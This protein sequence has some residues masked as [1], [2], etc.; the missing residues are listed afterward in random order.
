MISVMHPKKSLIKLGEEIL[1]YVHE[2]KEKFS[3]RKQYQTEDVN[4]LLD[5]AKKV[6]ISNEITSGEY[7]KL[8]RE[9]E[10]Q[11]AHLPAD[12]LEKHSH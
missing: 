8:V 7:K 9:L 2:L 10:S 5:F 1:M 4:E 11:G 3:I 12:E 6:Y